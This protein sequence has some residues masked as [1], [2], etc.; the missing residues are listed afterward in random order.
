[1]KII[2]TATSLA[3]L[4][5]PSVVA[6]VPLNPVAFSGT[7]SSLNALFPSDEDLIASLDRQAEYQ[8][9]AANTE[10][11]R[12]Y[13]HLQGRLVKTVGEAFEEFTAILGRPINALYKG[14]VSDIV[15][16]TH[17]ITVNARFQRDPVWS[18]GLLTAMDLIT[19]NYPEPDVG[20]QIVSALMKSIG[21]DEDELRAEAKVV[22][23]WAEGKTKEEVAAALKGE[24]DSIVS[25]VARDAK[26]DDF[27]MYSRF[28]GVGLIRVM[29]IVAP[30][31]EKDDAYTVM[32]QWV[33]ASMGK[34]S[35]TACVSNLSMSFVHLCLEKEYTALSFP[36]LNF[37]SHISHFYDNFCVSV[38]QRPLLQNESKAG[39]H[40]G[41]DEGGG[42]SGEEK[43]G[44]APR[45]EGR[46]SDR[47]GGERCSD[48]GRN[49][50]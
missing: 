1:M 44:G 7:D 5:A 27:W 32:E 26:A 47:P 49:R 37:S 3:L 31:T 16:T 4:L 28:F 22:S 21:M 43:D 42:D 30:G 40:G 2:A 45:G 14:A 39:H 15:G 13:G 23:D 9:G 19:K 48:G 17:L 36:R 41:D 50:C 10:F 34:S 33:G 6:F 29:E 38:G 20:Q 11:A 18:L 25:A 24:G 35:F 8:P 12:K 46:C